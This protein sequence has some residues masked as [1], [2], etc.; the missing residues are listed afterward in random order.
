M[1]FDYEKFY[2]DLTEAGLR[3]SKDFVCRFT[4]SLCAKPFLILTGLSGSGKTKLAQAF[5]RWI[6][7][8][9]NQY[10]LISVGSDWTNRE[11]LLGFTNALQEKKYVKSHSNIIDLLVRAKENP[12]L[13]YFIILDEMN[14][15]HVERY[16]SDFLSAMESDEPIHFHEG[17][18]EEKWESDTGCDVPGKIKL[19]DNLYIIGTVNIDETTYMF[20]P[21]VLDRAN[22]LEFRVDEQ[23]IELFFKDPTTPDLESLHREGRNMAKDFNRKVKSPGTFSESNKL[24]DILISSFKKLKQAGTEFGYRTVLEIVRLAKYIKEFDQNNN[25]DI[26][27]IADAAII[28]KLLPKLHGSRKK[29]GPIL[30]DLARLCIKN[31]NDKNIDAVLGNSAELDDEEIK[32]PN[33]LEK[34]QRM[35]NR[36]MQNGFTSFTEA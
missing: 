36:L 14:L 16:F 3:F 35:H 17:G 34:I 31:P 22:V 2:E 6:S 29:L 30:K 8:D 25:W 33:S 32:F 18:F 4:A 1:E 27:K 12:D 23:D 10:K 9:K 13:P 20:S 11:P 26:D 28:Q 5:A 7:K 21:K 24:K 19:P 15:S